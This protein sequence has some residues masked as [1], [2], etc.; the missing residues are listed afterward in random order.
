MDPGKPKPVRPVL[1]QCAMV[2]V[3][4]LALYA[5]SIG[6]VTYIA[7]RTEIT[8][9]NARMLGRFYTPVRWFMESTPIGWPLKKYWEWWRFHG[10]AHR[11]RSRR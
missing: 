8:D 7:I 9:N 5:L 6:P 2:G 4:A 11:N 10:L 1:L 3:G